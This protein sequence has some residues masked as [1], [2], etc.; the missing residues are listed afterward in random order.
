LEDSYP[1]FEIDVYCET[2]SINI[3]L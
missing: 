2:Y 1:Y 3:D